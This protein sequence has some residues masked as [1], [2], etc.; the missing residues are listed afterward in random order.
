[1]AEPGDLPAC[2]LQLLQ[3][4]AADVL[5]IAT[6]AAAFLQEFGETAPRLLGAAGDD[7]SHAEQAGGHG[8]LPGFG[9]GRERHARGLDAGDQ[10]MLRDRD[11]TGV[12]HE[13]LFV[14]GA[15]SGDQQPEIVGEIDLADQIVAQIVPANG[16]RMFIRGGDRRKG[17]VLLAYSHLYSSLRDPGF[18]LAEVLMGRRAPLSR[19]TPGP[20]TDRRRPGPERKVR[21]AHAPA[22]FDAFTV[23]DA[24]MNWVSRIV[25]ARAKA[26]A[27]SGCSDTVHPDMTPGLSVRR[28]V[29][30]L[31]DRQFVPFYF[32]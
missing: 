11:E 15:L 29:Q 28:K 16:D 19:S 3:R 4:L 7:R 12:R 31:L 30:R 1:M 9:S 13:A 8:A 20:W 25:E 26:P 24:E 18:S 10:S 21:R 23:T 17:L 6:G 32:Y 5:D 2:R 22:N 27:A 14:V